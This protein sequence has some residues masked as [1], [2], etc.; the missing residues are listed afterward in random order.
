MTKPERAVLSAPITD[1]A[2][3]PRLVAAMRAKI[4][5]ACRTGEVEALRVPIDWNEVRP[6]FERGAHRPPGT[7]PIAVLRELSYDGRGRE[8]VALLRAALGQAC[9]RET[10]GKSDM[11]VWPGFALAPPPAPT[12]DERQIMLACVRFAALRR[13]GSGPLPICRVGIGGD[14]VWHYFWDET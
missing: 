7:D 5:Q 10:R 12:D 1:T 14:G 6:L 11:Y 2:A 3:L 4:L 9:I 13:L 8:T